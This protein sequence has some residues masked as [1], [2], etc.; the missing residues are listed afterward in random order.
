MGFV[1]DLILIAIMVICIV[2]GAKKGFFKSLM[3]LLSG[4]CALLI[5][6][7]FTPALS[8][9]LNEQYIVEPI[10]EGIETTFLSIAENEDGSEYDMDLLMKDSQ[11]MGLMESAGYSEE[12]IE[13]ELYRS[14]ATDSAVISY[15]AYTVAEPMAKTVSDIIAFIVLFTVALIILKILTVI[16][17]VFLKLPVLKELD[18]TLGIVFGIVSALFFAYVF[19]MMASH[20]VIALSTAAPG[21]FNTEIIDGSLI[22]ELFAKYNP[23]SALSDLLI[24]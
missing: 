9:H 5:A 15:L 13:R 6:F 22:L 24:G 17:S 2:Y 1:L 19:A 11:F 16:I 3:S 21:T 18:R 8:L 10:A 14:E 20:L 23:I 12:E 7:T 4:I